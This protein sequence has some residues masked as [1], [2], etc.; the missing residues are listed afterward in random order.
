[1][2]P[3]LFNLTSQS[4]TNHS[5]NQQ[6]T[7]QPTNSRTKY[8]AL[9]END[10]LRL[11]D[12]IALKYGQTMSGNSMG[13]TAFDRGTKAFRE[14]NWDTAKKALLQVPNTDGT[15][16][17]ATQEMLAWLYFREK[18]YAEAVKCYKTYAAANPGP[19]ADL[20][21]LQFYLADY[22]N[23]KADFRKLLDEIL[24]PA[25]EHKFRDEAEKLKAGM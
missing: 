14:K 9:V 22:E 10:L 6:P 15:S 16:Y 17:A 21:L 7:A 18:K 4:S 2:L 12:D 1:S 25:N 20:H 23:S 24:D 13:S 8:V 11:G 5:T 3:L 19:G